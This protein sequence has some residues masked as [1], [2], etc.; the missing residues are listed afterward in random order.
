M[1]ATEAAEP[2]G[3]AR[4][5]PRQVRQV[6][7]RRVRHVTPAGARAGRRRAGRRGA[8]YLARKLG[9]Y[10]VAAWA[11]ITLNFFL[12]RL[13]P[14]NPVE[15]ILAHQAHFG[16]VPPGEAAA[17]TKLLGL[18]TGTIFAKYWQYLDSLAHLR[19]G[20]SVY[21]FPVP[22]S[23][24]I[25]QSILWTVI[26]VGTATVISF[27]VGIALGVLAGWK[28]GTWLDNVVPATTF[29][30]AMPY[31]W[32][33]LLLVYL[34]TQ[35]LPVFPSSGGYNPLDNVGFNG[36][37]IASAAQHSV[38]PALTIVVS[39]IGGW[40]LGMRNMMVST[41]SDDYVIAA[42]AK[43]LRPRRVMIGYVA[44][45]AV[46]P[47]VSGFAISLGF[48]VSGSIVME[49]VFNYPGIGNVLFQAVSNDD[50]PLM[51]GIFLVITL[52]VLGA[53]LLVDLLYG[54]IDPRT[55]IAW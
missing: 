24:V 25:R 23:T 19:M 42:E 47:S 53:N 21:E 35:V 15:I 16:V 17:L 46:L 29:L 39:S 31:F 40:L 30:T 32:L 43:G 54:F 36:P 26:L 14:G 37:F 6:T 49:Q 50:Y 55:R 38:L 4:T 1:A 18:G 9:F 51:Q 44:R 20:L 52:T 3:A 28:R 12:P 22:V 45:N 10:L 11:A 34:F 2:G 41:L 5:L 48:V 33:A 8:G 27:A 7:Q 13:I